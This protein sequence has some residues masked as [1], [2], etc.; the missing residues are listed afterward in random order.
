MPDNTL[1]VVPFVWTVEIGGDAQSTDGKR[2]AFSMRVVPCRVTVVPA[3]IP[4][5]DTISLHVS[6]AEFSSLVV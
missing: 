6:H 5:K 3:T 2:F 4:W 1:R